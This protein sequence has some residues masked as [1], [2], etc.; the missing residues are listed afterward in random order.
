MRSML[1]T[2]VPPNFITSRPMTSGAFPDD[3]G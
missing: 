1:A 2:E 3:S